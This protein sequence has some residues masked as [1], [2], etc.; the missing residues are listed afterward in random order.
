MELYRL[1]PSLVFYD[2]NYEEE[3]DLSL[4]DFPQERGATLNPMDVI[5]ESV[6][7]V[8]QEKVSQTEVTHSESS[9]VIS[10]E[11]RARAVRILSDSI[12]KR[13]IDLKELHSAWLKQLKIFLEDLY[14]RREDMKIDEVVY[15]ISRAFRIRSISAMKAIKAVS[16]T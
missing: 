6:F 2:L 15:E 4:E 8:T 9:V 12:R 16:I 3:V 1:K 7:N 13:E 11:V 10:Q 5:L 14:S